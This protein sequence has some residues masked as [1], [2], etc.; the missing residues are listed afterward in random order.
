[1]RR[2]SVHRVLALAFTLL[3]VV[4]MGIGVGGIPDAIAQWADWLQYLQRVTTPDTW[5]NTLVALGVVILLLLLLVQVVPSLALFGRNPKTK[6]AG[7]NS[8]SGYVD[9][10][11]VRAGAGHKV[12]AKVGDYT[13]QAATTN[14]A[15]YYQNLEV[16]PPNADYKGLQ[17]EFYVDGERVART[18]AYMGGG[19]RPNFWNLK[20]ESP[21][22]SAS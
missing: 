22:P 21:P 10:G 7:A 17:V 20:K 5:R 3:S 18:E 15:G 8:Y 19:H 14:D 2:Q 6:L 11:Q 13:S 16:N 4:L 1:M 12:V 9:Y